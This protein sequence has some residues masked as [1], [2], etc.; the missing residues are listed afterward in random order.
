MI[1]PDANLLLYAYHPRSSQHEPSRRW[2]EAILSGSDIVRFS[3]QTVWAFL[4]ISTNSKVFEHPLSISEATAA[5]ASWLARPNAGIIE[6]GERHWQILRSLLEDSQCAGPLVTD[7]TLAAVAI[8]H[9]ATLY[10]TDRDFSRFS[11]LVYANPLQ[12]E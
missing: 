8:E 9:G 12:K 1:L 7:A 3:W 4:R 11:S 5:V 6:P 2:L 10:T